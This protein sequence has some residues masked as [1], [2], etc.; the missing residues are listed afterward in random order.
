MT[1]THSYVSGIADGADATVVRPQIAWNAAHIIGAGTIVNAD[2]NV[3]SNIAESKILM[4]TG[5]HGHD[6]VSS[7]KVVRSPVFTVGAAATCDYVLGGDPA[8]TIE[9]A[10]AALNALGGGVL[11][12]VGPGETWTLN[13]TVNS[14]GANVTWISDYSLTLKAKTNL[15]A[16]VVS[17][18]H[19]NCAFLGLHLHGNK[20]NQAGAGNYNGFDANG[21][22]SNLLFRDCYVEQCKGNS[23]DLTNV[24]NAVVDHNYCTYNAW[25]G[26]SASGV[27]NKIINN[28]VSHSSDV[29]IS[30][31]SLDT[32][33]SNNQ[34]EDMDQTDGSVN[35]QWGIGL[36]QDAN[37]AASI[38]Q[39]NHIRNVSKGIDVTAT[40]TDALICD[41]ELWDWDRLGGYAAG[42]ET[43]GARTTI[44][45]NYLYGTVH[46]QEGIYVNAADDCV[47]QNNTLYLTAV[48]TNA[49]HLYN[50][51]DRCFVSGNKVKNTGVGISVDTNCDNNII[52]GNFLHLCVPGIYIVNASCDVNEVIHNFFRNCTGTLTDN[53]TGTVT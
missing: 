41:N 11:W 44:R 12:T 27:H 52:T 35:S 16:D 32:L 36:E 20:A 24:I 48:D 51:V 40:G 42:I 21:A 3:A 14:Q 1:I 38:I 15:N 39:G 2:I 23:H 37:I 31:Y 34:V 46:S 53:G 19:S 29:G 5:G 8:V 26:P 22:Y 6:G 9:T 30:I 28:Y 47:V 7:K 50:G 10:W 17:I 45:G 18:A 25:N 33:V 49:I 43:Q 13:T 4:S